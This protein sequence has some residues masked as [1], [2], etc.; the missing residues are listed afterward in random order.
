MIT[1]VLFYPFTLGLTLWRSPKYK[2]EKPAQL[3]F[4]LI[5]L[6]SQSRQKER[7]V[8]RYCRLSCLFFLLRNWTGGVKDE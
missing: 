5:F 8:S 3:G 6:R 4:L 2:K 7:G 1:L